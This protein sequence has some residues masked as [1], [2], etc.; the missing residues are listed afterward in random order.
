MKIRSTIL[1]FMKYNKRIGKIT[2]EGTD[3]NNDVMFTVQLEERNLL[4]YPDE[5]EEVNE[6]DANN[7]DTKEL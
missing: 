5:L 1:P 7:N 6:K 4:L 2:K 3:Y